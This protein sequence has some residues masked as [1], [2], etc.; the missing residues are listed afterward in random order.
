M[1]VRRGKRPACG[2][3]SAAGNCPESAWNQHVVGY[4]SLGRLVNVANNRVGWTTGSRAIA[5]AV[6]SSIAV[7][8]GLVGVSLRTARYSGHGRNRRRARRAK[9]AAGDRAISVRVTASNLHISAP[10]G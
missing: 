1:T 7:F 6:L 8:L 4:G 3:R 2:Q 9:L 5:F 10:G